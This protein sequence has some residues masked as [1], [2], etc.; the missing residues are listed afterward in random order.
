M[1]MMLNSLAYK[2]QQEMAETPHDENPTRPVIRRLGSL[3]VSIGQKMQAET[4]NTP[5]ARE[6]EVCA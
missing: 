2:L 1:D 3:L 6:I 5:E 4:Q